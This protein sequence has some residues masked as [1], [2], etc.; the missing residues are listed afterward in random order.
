M[1]Y[2]KN[3][4]F[5]YGW[6]KLILPSLIGLALCCG[7]LYAVEKIKQTVPTVK[8]L[9]ELSAQHNHSLSCKRVSSFFT[10][11]HYKEV[12]LDKKFADKVIDSYLYDN[13]VIC[14]ILEAL[15]KLIK[16]SLDKKNEYKILFHM[17]K[18]LMIT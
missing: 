12:I 1:K 11:S 9:P 14:N 4:V 13:E 16:S 10:R 18:L 17:N 2:N 8:D 3:N 6:R 7:P 15:S 5:G